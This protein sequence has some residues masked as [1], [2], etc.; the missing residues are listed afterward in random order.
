M[1]WVPDVEFSIDRIVK[2]LKE[3]ARVQRRKT[4]QSCVGSM[5]QF[6]KNSNSLP[7]VFN[8]SEI[9][10]SLILEESIG[11]SNPWVV[12]RFQTPISGELQQL[13][14]WTTVNEEQTRAV[15][16]KWAMDFPK[17]VPL[18]LGQE[19]VIIDREQMNPIPFCGESF[20]KLATDGKHHN[21]LAVAFRAPP[22]DMLV[23]PSLGDTSA[24]VSSKT[25][26][27]YIAE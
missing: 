14:I 13:K 4:A 16:I 21:N 9:D 26:A 5:F 25:A 12:G 8:R 27:G 1:I 3:D 17:S 11:D 6:L 10:I 20:H 22:E 2:S 15:A 18:V 24:S 7:F 23:I 19:L